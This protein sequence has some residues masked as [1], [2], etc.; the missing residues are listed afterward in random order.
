[1]PG[2]RWCGSRAAGINAGSVEIPS[3]PNRPRQRKGPP[4]TRG[5]AMRGFRFDYPNIIVE[6]RPLGPGQFQARH[7]GRVLV[8]STRQPFLDS[9]RQLLSEGHPPGAVLA[10]R[11]R[12]EADF[13]MRGRLGVA[14]RLTVKEETNDGKPRF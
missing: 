9:A 14:A 2:G 1:M 5:A 7:A 8:E 10:M 3:L 4:R 13:A 6:V 12:G 11:Y